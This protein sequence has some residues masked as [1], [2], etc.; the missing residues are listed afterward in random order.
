M[1]WVR[2]FPHVGLSPRVRG[3]LLSCSIARSVKGTIPACAGEPFHALKQNDAIGDYPRVC[4]GTS[5]TAVTMEPCAGLSPRVRGN[6]GASG[7]GEEVNGTIPACAGEPCR[8]LRRDCP[9][10]D[11]PRVCGGTMLEKKRRAA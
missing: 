2:K 8:R 11:Y 1:E 10:R 9:L 6:L 4:G 7:V 3:N 5:T